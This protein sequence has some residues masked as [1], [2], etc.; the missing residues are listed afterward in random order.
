MERK[1]DEK[2]HIRNRYADKKIER[3]ADKRIDRK[4]GRQTD[5]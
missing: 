5:K 1:I 3:L 4:I 2:I